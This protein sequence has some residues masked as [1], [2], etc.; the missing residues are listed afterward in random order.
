[1]IL[2]CISYEAQPVEQ[3]GGVWA[4]PSW[5]WQSFG[6]K[7]IFLSSFNSSSSCA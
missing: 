6:M 2:Q 7:L 3:Q 5:G 1:M 4:A